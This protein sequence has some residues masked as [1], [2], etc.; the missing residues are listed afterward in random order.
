MYARGLEESERIA[1]DTARISRK[2]RLVPAL[3]MQELPTLL[4]ALAMDDILHI[5]I[6]FRDNSAKDFDVCIR[7][8]PLVFRKSELEQQRDDL[9]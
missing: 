1:Q 8:F 3:V 7:V 6:V 9:S 2:Q 4:G 5:L